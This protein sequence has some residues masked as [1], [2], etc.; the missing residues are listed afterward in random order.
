MVVGLVIPESGS[1]AEKGPGFRVDHQHLDAHAQIM[2]AHAD[3]V[4][5][6][7]ATFASRLDAL[8]FTS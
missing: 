5:A 7:V 4:N 8:D 6:H 3:K 1:P 2:Q